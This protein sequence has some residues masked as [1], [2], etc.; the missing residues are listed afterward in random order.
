MN[1]IIVF[2]IFWVEKTQLQ[3]YHPAPSSLARFKT[4]RSSGS[5]KGHFVLALFFLRAVSTNPVGSPTIALSRRAGK[6][7]A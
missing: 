3:K 4:L 6:S 7:S 1:R 5:V 2:S